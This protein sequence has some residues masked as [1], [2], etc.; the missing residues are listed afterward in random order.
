M[1]NLKRLFIAAILICVL[2]TSI[3]LCACNTNQQPIDQQPKVKDTD[4]STTYANQEVDY[5]VKFYSVDCKSK[6]NATTSFVLNSLEDL[7]TLCDDEISPYFKTTSIEEIKGY[8]SNEYLND[9][10]AIENAYDMF[11]GENKKAIQILNNYDEDYFQEK[12]IVVLFRFRPYETVRYSLSN[13]DVNGNTL[14]I[15]LSTKK[16]IGPLPCIVGTHM[17]VIELEKEA[18][19]DVTKI[20]VNEIQI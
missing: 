7:N 15:I 4:E 12:S 16:P 10:A 3:I 19:A 17:Y 8:L 18:V 13:F 1:K 11:N 2:S 20:N 6:K 14:D 9:E 5:D